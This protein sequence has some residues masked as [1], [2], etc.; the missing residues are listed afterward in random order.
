MVSGR[1]EPWPPKVTLTASDGDPE[2]TVA[3]VMVMLTT[4]MTVMMVKVVVMVVV[5]VGS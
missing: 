1:L 4:M 2:R 5:E 3:M